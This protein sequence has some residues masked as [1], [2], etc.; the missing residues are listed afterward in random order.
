LISTAGQ[1]YLHDGD[2]KRVEKA[3]SGTPPVPNKLYWYDQ[4]GDVIYETDAAGNE[5]DRYYYFAGRLV[6]REEANDWVNKYGTDALGNVRFLYGR[7][8]QCKA[9]TTRTRPT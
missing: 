7:T 6:S 5:L 9:S 4:S 8:L 3:T 1:T 2:G